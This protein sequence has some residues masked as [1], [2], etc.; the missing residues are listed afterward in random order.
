MV[1]IVHILG[2]KMYER[3]P[4]IYQMRP[5]NITFVDYSSAEI[6]SSLVQVI[7]FLNY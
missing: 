2:N 6:N 1:F 7:S 4:S 5:L 3:C